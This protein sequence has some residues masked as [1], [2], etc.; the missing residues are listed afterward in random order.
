VSIYKSAEYL[1]RPLARATDKPTSHQA[2]EHMHESGKLEG[3]MAE[4]YELVKIH[5][6][7]TAFELSDYAESRS[8]PD[9]TRR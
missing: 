1:A 6:G 9:S 3:Q 8:L 5:P 4:V 2:A 7:C